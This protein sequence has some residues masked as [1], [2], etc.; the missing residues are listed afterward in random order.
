MASAG[1][2]ADGTD[3][4]RLA[5]ALLAATQGGLLLSQVNR[6]TAALTAAMDT[7]ITHIGTLLTEAPSDTVRRH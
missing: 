7:V 3:T 2:F 4:D 6:D 1:Q 5:L